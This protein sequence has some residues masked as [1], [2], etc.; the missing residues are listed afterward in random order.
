MQ[1]KLKITVVR[2]FT[3]DAAHWLP[4]YDGKCQNLHGHTFRLQIGVNG[5][6]NIMSGM[7]LDFVEL[8]QIIKTHVIDYLD[9]SLLNHTLESPTAEHLIAWIHEQLFP[10]LLPQLCLIRLWETQN[11]FA[12]WRIENE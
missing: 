9:H 8:N 2:E 7:V 5:F 6:P 12:E 4:D 11:S 3:F 10:I 1:E